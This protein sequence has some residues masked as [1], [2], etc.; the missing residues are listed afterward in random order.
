MKLDKDV[1]EG[2]K[3]YL[4]FRSKYRKHTVDEVVNGLLRYSL[5]DRG[6]IR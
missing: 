4:E 6:W 1:E 2:L 5:V 3:R